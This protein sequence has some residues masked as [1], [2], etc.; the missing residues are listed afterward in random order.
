[1]HTHTFEKMARGLA[2]AALCGWAVTGAGSAED[3]ATASGLPAEGKLDAHLGK[4]ALELTQVFRGERFPNIVVGVDGTVVATFGT[5]SVRARISQDADVWRLD[6]KAGEEIHHRLE[7]GR[8]AW[9]QVVRGTL[10]IGGETLN[11]G[12]AAA[13]ETAGT[14]ELR[15]G[16]DGGEALLFDIG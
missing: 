16:E 1:M 12:D 2:L 6:A 13:T 4:A 9:I 5:S 15:A 14:L 11:A 10:Q 3:Q 7:D 8:G